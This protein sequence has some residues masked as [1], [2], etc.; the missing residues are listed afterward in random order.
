MIFDIFTNPM[1]LFKHINVSV[2]EGVLGVLAFVLAI[3]LAI[4]VHEWAHAFSA[5]KCGDPTAKLAGRVTLNPIKHLH[6]VGIAMLLIAGFGFANPVPVNSLNFKKPKRDM[7]VVAS[8]GIITNIVS[9]FFSC[10]VLGLLYLLGNSNGVFFADNRFWYLL[11]YLFFY[12]VSFFLLINIGLALF[13]VL[14]IFPLDG[15]R[16][17]EVLI[18]GDNRF[19]KFLRSYGMYILL[20]LLLLGSFLPKWSPL[21]LYIV[22]ARNGIMWLFEKFWGLFGLYA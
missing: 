16:M 21:S 20:A 8:A 5:L 19:M 1:Q 2:A 3:L 13:N 6:P 18:G 11:F 17:L 15:Y 7:M 9:A 14:P 10:G 12:F 22:N 4:S